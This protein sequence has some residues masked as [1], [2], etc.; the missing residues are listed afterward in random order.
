VQ[1]GDVSAS[2]VDPTQ[3]LDAIEHRQFSRSQLLAAGAVA[4]G[5]VSAAAA[6]LAEAARRLGT[7]PDALLAK[8]KRGGNLKLAISDAAS[9]DSLDPATTFSIFGTLAAGMVYDRL[10]NLDNQWHVTPMLAVD[11][12]VNKNATVY[13]FKLRRG[14]HFH[15]GKEFTAHDVAYAVRRQ[16][17]KKAGTNG[18]ALFSPILAPSGIQV[19][20]KY[21]IRFHL[22]Q[23]DGFFLIRMGYTYSA[24]YEAG[25]NFKGSPGTG[26]FMAKFLKGGSGFRLVRNPHYWQHGLPYLDSISAVVMPEVTT[27]TAAVINGDTDMIDPPDW[28]AFNRI[29]GASNIK[30]L[31]SP[32]GPAFV[33]GIDGSVKP[34][35]DSRVRRAIKMLI[36]RQQFVQ[37]V[38]RGQATASADTVVNPHD[39]FYPKDLKPIAYDPEQ[40]KS[41]LK[42]A[43]Y[44][45][46]WSETIYTSDCCRGLLDGAVV[47]KAA[48]AAGGITANVVNTTFDE[49]FSKYWLQK[50]IVANYWL[51]LH[52]ANSF[53][54]MYTSNGQWN[55]S[56][57]KDPVIDKLIRQAQRS[58]KFSVQ[59]RLYAEV[60]HRYQNEG[61][62]IWPFHMFD[63]W[64]HK[65]NIQ[66]T[67][68]HPTDLVD[69]RRAYKT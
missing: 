44:G 3:D 14:V 62:S 68:I 37:V 2:G 31:K 57:I 36:N 11:W 61:A 21:T 65:K 51:R 69:F 7:D 38:C 26:P 40:A 13:T 29:Q 48:L 23:P 46:G 27:K 32:F 28:A 64:P 35:S 24:I 43:G 1:G 20:D 15:S 42:Q 66:G 39:P 58:T 12:S 18:Y 9:S 19:L 16:I 63:Y 67:R 54:F 33:F 4:L 8:P 45:N 52:P 60:Q 22:K 25:T 17:N 56:R 53:P 41:L 55:E 34:Y 50:P 5:G 49:L 59:K 47:L 6:P 30:V 10:V